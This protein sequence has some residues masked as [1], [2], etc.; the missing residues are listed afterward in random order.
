MTIELFPSGLA[1]SCAI[2]EG[3]ASDLLALADRLRE[4]E[5]LPDVK[6]RRSGFSEV[7]ADEECLY[8]TYT[9][10]VKRE[11]ESLDEEG[12]SQIVAV[13]TQEDCGLLV[14]RTHTAGIGKGALVRNATQRL[15]DIL[16]YGV[17]PIKFD[18]MALWAAYD[19]MTYIKSIHI[20]KL[21]VPGYKQIRLSGKFED[22]DGFEFLGVKAGEL[23]AL[24][25]RLKTPYG[26]INLKIS[27]SGKIQIYGPR[28][29]SIPSD[30]LLWLISYMTAT[31]TGEEENGTA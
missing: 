19:E 17:Y 8:L 26:F 20:A 6:L 21:A 15:A 13:H 9:S 22:I 11:V 12:K 5:Y 1:L 27:I 31:T 7:Q 2:H 24:T 23:K 4:D 14:G 28:E 18:D 10:F 3:G 29:E 16:G 25:G 30:Y